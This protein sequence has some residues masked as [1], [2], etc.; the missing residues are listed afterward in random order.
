MSVVHSECMCV[1]QCNYIEMLPTDVFYPSNS[2]VEPAVGLEMLSELLRKY[3]NQFSYG[4]MLIYY[5]SFCNSY[6]EEFG[7]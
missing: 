2:N 3:V 1:L 5:R 7:R 6:S 4:K